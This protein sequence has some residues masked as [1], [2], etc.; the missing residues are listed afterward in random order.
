VCLIWCKETL[1]SLKFILEIKLLPKRNLVLFF[2]HKLF[3]NCY[4]IVNNTIE[5]SR[6][7]DNA[8]YLAIVFKSLKNEEKGY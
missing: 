7:E 1:F 5:N 2:F 4:I 8:L 3:L 6:D